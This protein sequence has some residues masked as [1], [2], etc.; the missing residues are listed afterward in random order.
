[1][2]LEFMELLNQDASIT[3][4]G[5]R[6]AH[7]TVEAVEA[8]DNHEVVRCLVTVSFIPEVQAQEIIGIRN[9]LPSRTVVLWF[10][11]INLVRHS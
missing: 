2:G 10:S 7:R 8:L 11:R 4:S 9:W 6:S 3:K 5:R 1:M